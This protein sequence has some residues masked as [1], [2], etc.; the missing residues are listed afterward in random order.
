VN[1][2]PLPRSVALDGPRV[3][4]S[5]PVVTTGAA[6]PAQGYR[7]EIGTDGVRI[8]AADDAGAFYGRATLAQLEAEYGAALPSGTVED[9]PDLPVR[10][11]ML[12]ISRCRRSTRC[13]R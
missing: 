11:V 3:A 9:W 4:A 2:L 7:L 12:D 10:G 1:L 6:L 5:E 8:A 13:A